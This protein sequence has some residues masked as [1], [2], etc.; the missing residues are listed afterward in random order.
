MNTSYS[1]KLSSDEARSRYGKRIESIL[2][3]ADLDKLKEKIAM[4]TNLD[5]KSLSDKELEAQIDEVLSVELTGGIK[6]S[7]TLSEYSLFHVGRRFYR[8]RELEGADMPNNRLSDVSAYWNPPSVCVKRYGRLNKPGET[9][10]YTA[11]NPYTAMCEANIKTGSP[12]VLCVYESIRPLRFSWIG[13][14]A[15]YAFNGINSR[16]AIDFLE[17]IRHFLVEEFTRVV[18]DGDESLYRITEIIAKKYYNSPSDN[19]WRYPS[20][21]NNFEDNICF[22]SEHIK[23]N[24]KLVGAIV[25]IFNES[26]ETDPRKTTMTARYVVVGSNMDKYLPYQ[27]DDGEKYMRKLFPEFL[28]VQD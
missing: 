3:H 11:L 5:I 7:T 28:M 24:L 9:L 21:K 2:G 18:P 19:G 6:V 23:H 22:R 10:L 14:I 8:V 1:I 17:T 16:S 25:A 4:F 15:N 12:F 13:G 20:I 27:S 26:G